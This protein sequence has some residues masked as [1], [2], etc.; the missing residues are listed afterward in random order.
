[1]NWYKIVLAGSREDF[2][3]SIG[4]TEDIVSFI[5]SQEEQTA[6][7]MTNE[8]RKN[9]Q[10]TMQHLQQMIMPQRRQPDFSKELEALNMKFDDEIVKWILPYV[11]TTRKTMTYEESSDGWT[12][13]HTR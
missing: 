6:N 13:I 3:R 8:F 1:M 7:I 4:A 5:A 10:L 12:N 2:L 9:P 11:R